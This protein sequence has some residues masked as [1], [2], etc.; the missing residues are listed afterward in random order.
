MVQQV[1]AVVTKPEDL[2]SIPGTRMVEAVN[3]FSY[4]VL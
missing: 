2:S 4:V 1:Q 3:G